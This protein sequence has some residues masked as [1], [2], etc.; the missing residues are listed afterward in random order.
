M[1]KNPHIKTIIIV[2]VAIVVAVGSFFVIDYLTRETEEIT[3]GW[4]DDDWSYRK[5]IV[6][7]S[8][9]VTGDLTDFPVLVSFTDSSFGTHIQD[10]GEDIIFLDSEGK[11]LSHEI[12]SVATSTGVLV[13]WVKIPSLS[14]TEDT[15]LN[16]YYGN[17]GVGSQQDAENV[18]DDN[19]KGV[20]HLGDFDSTPATT[21]MPDFLDST[22]NNNDGSSQNMI[23]GLENLVSTSTINGG[24]QFDGVDDYIIV[25]NSASL[26]FPTGSNFT[27]SLWTKAYNDQSSDTKFIEK[28]TELAQ[29]DPVILIDGNA[30]NV[31]VTFD[32]KD[33]SAAQATVIGDLTVFDDDNWHHIVGV[34]NG[35]SIYLYVDSVLDGT[36]SASFSSDW[37]NGKIRF[38]TSKDLG[39]RFLE[40]NLDEVR[41][42]NIARSTS[43]IET[44]YNNQ[45]SPQ[46]FLSVQSEETGPGPVGYWTFDEGYGTTAGDESGQGND[47]TITGASW[48]DESMCVSGKCLYFDGANNDDEVKYGNVTTFDGL[49]KMTFAAWIKTTSNTDQII[50]SEYNNNT[51]NRSY[52]FKIDAG[53]SYPRL[54]VYY[55]SDGTGNHDG[56]WKSNIDNIILNQWHYVAASIDLSSENCMLY[57]DGVEYSATKFEDG[58]GLPSAIIDSSAEF[59]IG[60]LYHNSDTDQHF[61]GFI[62]EVKIYPYARSADE[63]RQD[64]NAGI[65]GLSSKSGSSVSFGAKSDKWMSDGLVGYWP[66]DE[67]ATTSGAVDSSGNGNDGT[68]EGHA[69]TTGGK[70][71][72]GGVFDGDGD[73]ITVTDDTSLDIGINDISISVW[74]NVDNSDTNGDFI[75]KLSSQDGYR[76]RQSSANNGSFSWTMEFDNSGYIEDTNITP[77]PVA[78]E[79]T[80]LVFVADRSANAMMYIN[81]E[82]SSDSIVDISEYNNADISNS[83]DLFIGADD[84]NF[85]GQID[86]VR[87]YNRALSPS[88]VKMLYEWAPGPVAHW[89]FDEL[90]GDTAYDSAASTTLTG[91]NHGT[92]GSGAGADSADPTWT[93]GKYGG[94]LEFDE[95]GDYVT[96][97]P[98]MSWGSALSLSAWIKPHFEL[99][100]GEYRMILRWRLD[101]SNEI[102]LLKH[103]SN[104]WRIHI[105]KDDSSTDAEYAQ[106]YTV[107]TWHHIAGTSDSSGNVI[108]Y[109]DGNEIASDTGAQIPSGS[110][111]F[112]INDGVGSSWFNGL[113]DDVRIYNYARTQKQILEDMGAG[114]PAVNRPVL[115][116]KFDEGYGA[117]AY[118][119]SGFGNNGSLQPGTLGANTASSAMWSLDGK[120]GRAMEFDGVDDYVDAG[121]NTSL[122]FSGDF[123]ASFWVKTNGLNDVDS[124]SFID[125]ENYETDGWIIGDNGPWTVED[126]FFRVNPGSNGLCINAGMACIPRSEVNDNIWHNIV[127]VLNGPTMKLYLD[128]IEKVSKSSG[129][130]VKNTSKNMVIGDF[131]GNAGGGLIDEVK[132]YNYALTSDEVHSLYNEGLSTVLGGGGTATTTATG[133]GFTPSFSASRKYCI[134]GDTSQCDPPVLDLSFDEKTGTTTYDKSGQGNDGNFVS[135][136]TSPVWRDADQCA[137]GS[138]LEL[139]GSDDYVDLGDTNNNIN[140]LSFWVK[141]NSTTEVMIDLDGGI[142]TASSTS[143]TITA[144]GFVSPTVYVDGVVASTVTTGWHHIVFTTDTAI[145]ANDVDIG[146]VG[147]SY[148]DGKIDHVRLYNYARTPAQIAWD[149]NRGKPIA[150]WSFDECSGDTVYD[151]SVI[152]SS[153]AA[154]NGTLNLGTSGVTATSTCASS[155]DGF[156]YNGKDGKINSAG[157]FDGGDDMVLVTQNSTINLTDKTGY[158]VAA[159]VFADSDGESSK[160]QIIQ[161]GPQNYLRVDSES[162]NYLDVEGSLDLQGSDANLNITA[163]IAKNSW[164]HIVMVYEN[165]ADDEMDI[166]INGE[167]KGTSSGGSGNPWSESNDLRIGGTSSNNFDGKLDEVKIWNYALTPLQVQTE[168]NNGAAS[169]GF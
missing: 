49:S 82:L 6:I 92:L 148:F 2:F 64:Y 120:Q 43:T 22:S 58:S 90:T 117:T 73:Y 96:I 160:G 108:L 142:H 47:G 69:S 119:S 158:T 46:T 8:D 144:N 30:S 136:A 134:P 102:Q 39:N 9:Y 147:S 65:S 33:E 27:F 97:S 14:S 15:V 57:V 154:N 50:L 101:A 124:T 60:S 16:M 23:G 157:S 112:Y 66:M 169:F 67:S 88:E 72:N 121:N 106:T 35:N 104:V 137:K 165:D 70:F 133:S 115:E 110:S 74:V 161:K 122:Q 45:N 32:V 3:A 164:H 129:S 138:C 4:W 123:T 109:W 44:S 83:N 143:G 155:T 131:N 7:N 116:L 20:W 34:K 156:W 145:D 168:Y 78:G 162:G 149:Y 41:I 38:G 103:N 77:D 24:V 28:K 94:A 146:R 91:G 159:W 132:V 95:D 79:W 36:D 93:Q 153:N 150:H 29:T 118:D 135:D 52:F 11:K 1:R 167:H 56:Y 59:R 12:E 111:P 5:A 127:G 130:Y 139:D 75:N 114:G 68:Y 85:E 40:G 98:D 42:S 84:A 81:G 62:D 37:N 51:D 17:A 86:E 126:V 54:Y 99:T 31:G 10:N 25:D 100:D 141:A 63:I 19:F 125:K 80:H 163:G 55:S 61:E 105:E 107:G 152:Y 26:S 151:Q 18:W 76:L 13:A 128:G 140:T 21:T 89:R 113:I 166:Y 48:Q 87:I 71:G 53:S